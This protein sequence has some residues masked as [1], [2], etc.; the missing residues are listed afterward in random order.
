MCQHVSL[1]ILSSSLLFMHI[2][3]LLGWSV[4]SLAQQ[5][6]VKLFNALQ[7]D[8]NIKKSV[9]QSKRAMRIGL[10]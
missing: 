6:A 1:F 5:T 3:V 7:N 2:L 10:K 9:V 8:S 4:S